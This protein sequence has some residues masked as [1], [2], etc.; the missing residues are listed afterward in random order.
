MKAL[1][2]YAGPAARRHIEAQGLRPQDVRTI[3]GAAGGP[4]G[5][6]LGPIDR[7]VFGEWLAQSSQPVHLVGASIG[8]WRLATACLGDPVAAFERFEHDY[9]RQ[10]F[11]VPPG[12]KR[13]SPHQ[14]SERFA[15][16]LQAFYGGRIGEVLAHPRYRLHVVTSRGRHILG[17]EGRARTPVGYLGAFA[18]NSVH[19]KTLGA[20]LERCVFSTP[21]AELPFG[22]RDFRTRQ[23]A[24]REDNFN[25]VLQA[26]CSIPFLLAAVHDIPGAPRGAYWDGG[27]TD[28]HLHLDYQPVDDGLVLYPHFQRAVVPGWLDKGLRWRHKSTGFLDRMVVLAPDPDWVKT[29]P[30]GKLPDRKDFIHFQNDAQARIAAW[31][32]ATREA[33]RLSD[34]LQEWLARGSAAEILPL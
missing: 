20:W 29:L 9:V 14:L 3:P 22:T 19:R 2:I 4:K 30:N 5:L 13:L 27:I 16:S 11:E 18:S 1:R 33:E 32:R 26:S 17:R 7:F 21:G 24:L 12:Q 34:E 10:Q 8:A 31:T 28:Y 6:I 25:L 23:H 15:E